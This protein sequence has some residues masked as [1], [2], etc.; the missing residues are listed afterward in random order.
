MIGSVAL[1]PHELIDNAPELGSPPIVYTRLMDIINDPRTGPGH[2]AEVISQDTALT[3]RI[4]KL[5]NS[6][7]FSFGRQIDTVE[8]AVSLVGTSQVRDL[9]LATSVTTFFINVTPKLI[10]QG[11]FWKH[12]L[13][14]GVGA[15]VIATLCPEPNVERFFVAGMLHDVG[16]L[17]LYLRA[18][19]EAKAIVQHARAQQMLL[20]EAEREL[21][22]FDHGMIGGALMEHWNMPESLE[23]SI[24]LHHQPNEATR[25]PLETAIVH[26]ADIFA[27]ELELG[28]SGE[29]LV[30]PRSVEAC[31]RLGFDPKLLASVPDEIERQYRDTVRLFGLTD[32]D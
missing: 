24:A 7:F 16:R 10:H 19:E 13:A 22:G 1:D 17:V 5:V 32:T 11:D 12:S 18:P 31:D 21:T 27:H 23:E 2:I 26:L 14:T 3:V 28:S 25:Y 9:A 29:R 20:Y 8:Q 6:A 30:P 15:R 4:L